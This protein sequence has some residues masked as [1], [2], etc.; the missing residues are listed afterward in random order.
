VKS[1][2][3]VGRRITAVRQTRLYD[4]GTGESFYNLDAIVLDDGTTIV[5][6]SNPYSDGD[7]VQDSVTAQVV[8]KRAR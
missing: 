4:H 7:G 2:E 1:R 8:K 5:L 6:D 3:V